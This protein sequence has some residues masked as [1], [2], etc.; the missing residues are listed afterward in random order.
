MKKMRVQ[1]S[2]NYT[3][4]SD[5]CNFMLNKKRDGKEGKVF[6]DTVGYYSTISQALESFVEENMRETSARTVKGLVKRHSELCEYV[7]GLFDT[8]KELFGAKG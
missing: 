2:E 5:P 1:L 3:L 4:T 6:W 8:K 7:R